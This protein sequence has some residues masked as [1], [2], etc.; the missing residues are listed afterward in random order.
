[1]AVQAYACGN[2]GMKMTDSPTSRGIASVMGIILAVKGPT[3]GI[4]SGII[5]W[6]IIEGQDYLEKRAE[7]KNESSVI[8]PED[9][10]SCC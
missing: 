2:I 6:L 5:L 9:K 1:M 3:M 8:S 4:I 7:E 10:K